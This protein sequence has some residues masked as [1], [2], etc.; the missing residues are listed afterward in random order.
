[1]RYSLKKIST[2]KNISFSVNLNRILVFPSTISQSEN[3][4]FANPKKIFPLFQPL[5]V[6]IL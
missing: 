1:M 4:S 3:L 5:V 6:V 2:Q